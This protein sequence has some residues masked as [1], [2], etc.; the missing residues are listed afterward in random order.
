MSSHP[1]PVEDA[2]AMVPTDTRRDALL[3]KIVREVRNSEDLTG[4]ATLSQRILKALQQVPRD[5]FVPAALQDAAYMDRPLPIGHAQTISQ[6]YIVA[7]MTELL[8]TQ[9][10]DVVLE[11]GTGSGYQAAVLAQLVSHVYSVE[12]I[13]ALASEAAQRLKRLGYHNVSVRCGDGNLGW[14]SHAPFDAIIV[15]AAAPRVPTALI[16][17]LRPGGR[18]VIPVGSHHYRQDLR[19]VKK[20]VT[21]SIREWNVLPVVFVP[22]RCAQDAFE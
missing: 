19:V 5:A 16:D 11:I 12:I 17:Q 9:P 14:P 21:G 15:T 1:T 7:L 4:R 18:M 2:S 3:Q 20:E 10:G 13:E 6:P 22:L 8:E